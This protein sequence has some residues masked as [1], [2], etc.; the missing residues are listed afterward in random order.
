MGFGQDAIALEER[1]PEAN[2]II[3]HHRRPTSTSHIMRNLVTICLLTCLSHRW[4]SSSDALPTSEYYN[5]EIGN[6]NIHVD[7]SQRPFYNIAHMANSIKKTIS[8]LSRGANAVEVDVEYQDDDIYL[9]HGQPCD[10]FRYCWDREPL[11]RYL[12]FVNKV[13]SPPW[14]QNLSA[15]TET[16]KVYLPNFTVLYFDNKLKNFGNE[17]KFHNGVR[18]ANYLARFFFGQP[19]QSRLKLVVSIYYIIDEDFLVGF[20]TRL[21]ELRLYDNHKE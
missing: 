3:H 10:C 2:F 17:Q 20:I 6:N 12:E 11:G 1:S 5:V 8:F 14:Q 9:Y 19:G 7:A 18:F 21:K 4:I 15:S 16:S 13:T